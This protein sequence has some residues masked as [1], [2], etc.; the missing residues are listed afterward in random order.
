MAVVKRRK[1][2]LNRLGILELTL[3]YGT[4]IFTKSVVSAFSRALDLALEGLGLVA[5]GPL[6]PEKMVYRPFGR[7]HLRRSG[8][9]LYLLFQSK[10]SG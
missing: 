8:N 2:P 4:N 10:K 5:S 6:W 7:E 9:P 1:T 3:K